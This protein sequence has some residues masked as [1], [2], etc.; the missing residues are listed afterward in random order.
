MLNQQCISLSTAPTFSFLERP[1]SRKLGTLVIAF[2]LKAKRRNQT[3]LYGQKI[4]TELCI[5]LFQKRPFQ[6]CEPLAN[7]MGVKRYFTLF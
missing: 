3:L 2:Y 4:V 5:V 6:A 7:K 1:S